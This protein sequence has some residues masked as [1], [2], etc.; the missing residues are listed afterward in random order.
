M[1]NKIILL[2]ILSASIFPIE[3]LSINAKKVA[4]MQIIDN[5]NK[6]EYG[7]KLMLRSYLG[8]AITSTPGYIGLE[9]V[10]V[11]AIMDEQDFQRT[12]MVNENQI[13]QLGE[14]TGA[15]YILV[16][17]AAMLNAN[18]I[19]LTAKIINIESAQLENTANIQ[20]PITNRELENNC[21]TLAGKLFMVDMETGTINSELIIGKNRYI[22]EHKNGQPHGYGTMYYA[23]NDKEGRKSYQGNWINGSKNG[24]GTFYWTN[25]NKYE[26]DWSYDKMKGKGTMD[27]AEND[28]EGRKRYY[29]D[30]VD[31]K[32][33]GKGT[34]I[35]TNGDKF[36]G[37]CTNGIP[38][39][40][41]TYYYSNGDM[42]SGFFEGNKI[43][44]I[45]TY[46]WANGD[47]YE[48]AYTEGQMN[49]KGT[50]YYT[51]GDRYEG[52][53][54]DNKRSGEGTYYFKDGCYENHTYI[55][56]NLDGKLT[57]YNSLGKRIA[58]FTYKE[59]VKEREKFYK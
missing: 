19:F 6:V 22:G 10:D 17:E 18:N 54:T 5:E 26:G 30:W 39:G 16:A 24:K 41:G 13:K 15:D 9:R 35:W 51:N 1:K 21:R 36:E 8:L 45:G 14:M 48:G 3:A 27:F 28:P 46:Y 38:N 37:Y 31:S 42:C 25:G 56:G 4:I 49:G 57:R 44:G 47:R 33:S 23:E 12:G 40:I 7:V 53:F 34:L 55:N 50:F 11:S 29:G 2:L 43:K 58:V 59:G 32:M 20:S 52:F